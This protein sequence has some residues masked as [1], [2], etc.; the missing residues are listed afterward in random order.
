MKHFKQFLKEDMIQDFEIRFGKE[1]DWRKAEKIVM[2]YLKK[3]VPKHAKSLLTKTSVIGPDPMM[4]A[5]GD[6]NR[7]LKPPV[8]LNKLY[9]TIRKLPSSRDKYWISI[10]KKQEKD[11]LGEDLGEKRPWKKGWSPAEFKA[12]SNDKKLEKAVEKY[13][14][15]KGGKYGFKTVTLKQAEKAVP[16]LINHIN[17]NYGDGSGKGDITDK[18]LSTAILS[19]YDLWDDGKGVYAYKK[20]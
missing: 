18:F 3:D 13:Y 6:T 15:M 9:D 4:V 16:Y 12:V 2:A 1:S 11:A 20:G 8:N 5:V 7:K 14:K 19:H 17:A 10:P